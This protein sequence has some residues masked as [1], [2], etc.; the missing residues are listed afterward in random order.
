MTAGSQGLTR[1]KFLRTA[2]S[3]AAVMWMSGCGLLTSRARLPDV[4]QVGAVGLFP[5]DRRKYKGELP[6]DALRAAVGRLN[7]LGGIL[8]KQVA[9]RGAHAGTEDEALDG[10]QRFL[11]DPTVIGV[12]LATPLGADRIADEAG[13]HGMPVI[14][15]TVD[16]TAASGLYPEVPARETLFQFAIPAEWSLRVLCEY[17]RQ[18]RRYSSAGLLYDEFAFPRVR[19]TAERIARSVGLDLVWAEEFGKG[20]RSLEEQLDDA[21]EAHPDALILWGDAEKAAQVSGALA[22]R[23]SAYESSPV[24]RSSSAALWR[25]HL[26]GNP[27]AMWEPDWALAEPARPSPGSVSVGDI[28][29][30]RKGPQWLPEV[31]GSDHVLGWEKDDKARRGLRSVVDSAYVLF[32]AARRAGRADREAVMGVLEKEHEYQFA[33][34]QFSLGGPRRIA[35]EPDDLCLMVLERA[36]PA[37]AIPPYS[38]GREWSDGLMAEHDMTV[39]LRP[40]LEANLRRAPALVGAML[41]GGYGTECAKLGDGKLSAVCTLH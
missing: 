15:A 39:L 22:Q 32:E 40:R 17:A 16:F 25:P 14:S 12:V 8:G 6:E 7:A 36:E 1:R 9:Y 28:G 21:G 2:G 10:F 35:L 27:E 11:A 5:G 3:A 34:V 33:S 24:A 41:A 4:V 37:P 23:G 19:E 38:L 30:F 13:R 31:W 18:D 29:G 20:E 26:M